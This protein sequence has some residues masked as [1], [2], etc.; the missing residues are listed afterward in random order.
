[1]FFIVPKLAIGAF[2]VVNAPAG[3]I[4][5]CP[6]WQAGRAPPA[7]SWKPP[8]VN[9]TLQG[10]GVEEGSDKVYS[11]VVPMK[12]PELPPLVNDW[13]VLIYDTVGNVVDGVVNIKKDTFVTG[14]YLTDPFL[15]WN[16]PPQRGEVS[17]V[18]ISVSLNRRIGEVQLGD[19]KWRL[20]AI[21][22]SMPE[23]YRH[24]IRHPNQFKC[25]S[26][27]FPIAIDVPWR[28]YQ[29][30]RWLRVLIAEAEKTV[31]FV[32]SGTYQFQFPVMI[33]IFK[34]LATEWY[35]SLC[36]DYLCESVS[37]PSPT[38]IVSFPMPNPSAMLPPKSFRPVLA[39]AGTGR[40]ASCLVLLSLVTTALTIAFS[41]WPAPRAG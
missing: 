17:E 26:K 16:I 1:V 31:D 36:S 27:T 21:L 37:P 34:P 22:L 40:S 30:F 2:A 13:D 19:N 18:V 33:P 24:D 35:F 25:L 41:T 12:T 38:V 6:G 20:R 5:A 10:M 11:F 4:L 14:M 9:L 23:G 32:P 3:F 39:T 8:M 7:C 15:Q 29:N 28:N